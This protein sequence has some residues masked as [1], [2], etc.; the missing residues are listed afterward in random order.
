MME[1][2]NGVFTAAI[3]PVNNFIRATLPS[4]IL[5]SRGNFLFHP[6]DR[7]DRRWSVSALAGDPVALV[8]PN[9]F[10]DR[11]WLLRAAHRGTL[12]LPWHGTRART[13]PC[14]SLRISPPELRSV[15]H[16]RVGVRSGLQHR[17]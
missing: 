13:Q 3:I 7:A 8:R 14:L 1:S 16:P 12:P 9:A 5:C 6:R 17:Q 11:S 4:V 10:E 2:S 15:F